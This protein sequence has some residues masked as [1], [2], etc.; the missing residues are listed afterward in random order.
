[1]SIT[2][3]IHL[4]RSSKV[5]GMAEF[6][7]ICLLLL[8]IIA[9]YPMQ[10]YLINKKIHIKYSIIIAGFFVIFVLIGILVHYLFGIPTMLN[11][12]LG[13]NTKDAVLRTREQTTSSLL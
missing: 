13:L 12:Y 11:Y 10:V 1:M 4:L 2:K 9:S 3:L 8:S 6:D 5:F 7:F